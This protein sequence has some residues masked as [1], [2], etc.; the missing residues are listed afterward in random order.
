VTNV[1]KKDRLRQRVRD[2]LAGAMGCDTVRDDDCPICQLS[3]LADIQRWITAID[4]E[5]F[6]KDGKIP[7][8]DKPSFCLFYLEDFETVNS[9]TDWLWERRKDWV[10]KG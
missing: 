8:N 3:C 4:I 9:A 7:P 10:K 5:F 6:H 1:Q 2:M